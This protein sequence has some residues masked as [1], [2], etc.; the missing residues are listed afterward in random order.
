MT[1]KNV[2]RVVGG[3]LLVQMAVLTAG[4][5]VL[6]PAVVVDYLPVAGG[7][8]TA[9]RIAVLLLL[10]AGGI[11]LTISALVFPVLSKYSLPTAVILAALGVVWVMTQAVDNVHISSML[12][13]SQRYLAESAGA[14]AE[15]YK[16]LAPQVRATRGAAHYTLL[17]AIDVW[18]AVFYAAL[19]A[20]RLVPRA[21]AAVG[22]LGVGVHII[23]I[24][25]SFFVGYPII[26]TAAYGIA[27]SYLLVGG[28]LV[29]RGFAEREI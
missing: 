4:F 25:M 16:L 14:N 29:V 26:W 6:K 24:P 5:M 19:F 10:G 27:I 21:V 9:V 23:G 3:L 11:A 18:F 7:L 28:W 8:D 12:S 2:G 17:L 20:F 1:D 22:L 13:L 15:L